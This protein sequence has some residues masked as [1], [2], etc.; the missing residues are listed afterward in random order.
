MIA[1]DSHTL[2]DFRQKL[3]AT[4]SFV[5]KSAYESWEDL[6][7]ELCGEFPDHLCDEIGEVVEEW[8]NANGDDSDD[9]E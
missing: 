5:T 9:D 3:D 8:W 1:T 7:E 4:L 2:D 6:Q